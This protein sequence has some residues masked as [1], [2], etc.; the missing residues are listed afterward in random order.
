MT[1][2]T[3]IPVLYINMPHAVERRQNVEQQIREHLPFAGPV[4]YVEGVD[5]GRLEQQPPQS[6]PPISP[7]ARLTLAQP[8]QTTSHAQIETWGAIG[9]YESHVRCWDWLL[10]APPQYQVMLVLED[11]VCFATNFAAVWRERVERL[12]QPNVLPAWDALML[13]FFEVRGHFPISVGGVNGIRA[14]S[15]GGSFFGTH[16]YL[17]TRHGAAL[18]R[19]SAYPIEVQVDAYMLI[20]QQIADIRLYLVHEREIVWQ[21]LGYHEQGIRHRF[22][23]LRVS[24]RLMQPY[25]GRAAVGCAVLLLLVLLLVLVVCRWR[26]AGA[27]AA[28]RPVTGDDGL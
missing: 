8:E 22:N 25:Q 28:G 16:A 26:R 13:G 17:V 7:F 12:V 23:P 2:M 1:N 9:C 18:L 10:A 20:L 15:N 4:Q 5:G 14:L 27:A 21:C 6:R 3:A 24:L 19:R 11:D